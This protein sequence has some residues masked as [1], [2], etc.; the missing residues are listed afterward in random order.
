MKAPKGETVTRAVQ[1]CRRI[2]AAYARG[3]AT[4]ADISES[5]RLLHVAITREARDTAFK[6][7]T[8]EEARSR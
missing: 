6:H 4:Q 2:D 1:R 3:Y 7:E 5:E 8:R